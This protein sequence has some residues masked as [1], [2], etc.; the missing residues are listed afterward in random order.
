MTIIDIFTGCR[1]AFADPS[2][3][4]FSSPTGFGSFPP[5]DCVPDPNIGARFI[6]DLYEKA[7]DT[8]GERFKSQ[9]HIHRH[10]IWS[11]SSIND[12]CNK[13]APFSYIDY[14][15]GTM[16]VLCSRKTSLDGIGTFR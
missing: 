1:W 12:R 2:D 13:S 16:D 4:P 3:K 14:D 10:L 15:I 9:Y 8:N 6:R 5:T 7:N 11:A